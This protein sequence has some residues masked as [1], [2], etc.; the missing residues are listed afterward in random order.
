MLYFL[1]T[2]AIIKRYHE[3]SGTEFINSIFDSTDKSILVISSFTTIETVATLKKFKNK[4]IIST[5]DFFYSAS[6][7]NSE[8]ESQKIMV[9]D[10]EKF[11]I[12][13]AYSL[14]LKHNIA[15]PDAIIL[16]SVISLKRDFP[17]FVCSDKSLI[18]IAKVNN[19]KVINPEDF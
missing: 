9:I 14:I 11:H 1:D 13:Y 6:K 3:E 12:T 19:I 5:E 7:F 18:E 17:T 8:C 16:A 15:A 10:I 4:K 2:S